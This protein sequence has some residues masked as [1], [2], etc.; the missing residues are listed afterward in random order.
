M[1]VAAAVTGGGWATVV[2]SGV[3]RTFVLRRQLKISP[4][5]QPSGG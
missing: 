3:N 4:R 5:L 1:M 2:I